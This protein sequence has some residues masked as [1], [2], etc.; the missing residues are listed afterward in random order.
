MPVGA[1]QRQNERQP[2]QRGAA[3]LEAIECRC[4]QFA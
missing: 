2:E 4:C 1:P 3:G